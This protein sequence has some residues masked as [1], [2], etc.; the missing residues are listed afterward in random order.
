MKL[1]KKLL[2]SLLLL[3]NPA[4]SSDGT[5]LGTTSENNNNIKYSLDDKSYNSTTS[6]PLDDNS[7]SST[8]INLLD[9]TSDNQLNDKDRAFNMLFAHLTYDP[10]DDDMSYNPLSIV[11][12][13]V[14]SQKYPNFW[15]NLKW[16]L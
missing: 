3:A 10:L 11:N 8:D 1:D 5:A 9:D 4:T 16:Y 13:T 15:S 7:S 12:Q 2:L 6:P 14:V